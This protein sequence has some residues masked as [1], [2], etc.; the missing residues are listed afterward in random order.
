MLDLSR[1][2]FEGPQ[3]TAPYLYSVNETISAMKPCQIAKIVKS[4]V[5]FV[6]EVC[7][8]FWNF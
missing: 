5:E 2:T 4:R 8:N 7:V 6:R 3:M 1:A